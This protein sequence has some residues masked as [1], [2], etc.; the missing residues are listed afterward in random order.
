MKS[1]KQ[2]NEMLT[3]YVLGELSPVDKD[4]VRYHLENCDQ[5]RDQ[6]NRLERLINYADKMGEVG[7]DEQTCEQARETLLAVVEN[8][9]G[10]QSGGAVINQLPERRNIMKNSIFKLSA[11][12]LILIA[13]VTAVCIFTINNGQENKGRRIAGGASEEQHR[14]KVEAEQVRIDQM[15]A[16]HDVD[17]L[18]EMVEIG[19]FE[20]KLRAAALLGEIGDVR[21]LPALRN[22][23][24]VD[25]P[26]GYT[27]EPVVEAIENIVNST[28]ESV[29]DGTQDSGVTSSTEEGTAPEPNAVVAVDKQLLGLIPAETAFCAIVNNFDNAFG[30]IDQYAVGISPVPGA[31]TVGARALIVGKLGNPALTGVNTAGSF[32]VFGKAFP[33]EP[34]SNPI[35]NLLIGFLVP[36]PDYE[37]FVEGN[38]NFGAAD[39]N[40]ISI[41]KTGGTVN[42]DKKQLGARLGGYVLV[43]PGNSYDKLVSVVKSV[44]GGEPGI[45]T[46]LDA[47]MA[48][49][50][51]KDSLWGYS[52]VPRI[53]QVFGP[54]IYSQIEKTK[55][56][57]EKLNQEDSKANVPPS[58]VMNMYFGMLEIITKELDSV[59]VGLNYTPAVGTFKISVSPVA[60][61]YLAKMF[62]TDTSDTEN[63]YLGYLEDGAV[64]NV[65]FKINKNLLQEYFLSSFDLM[66]FLDEEG[67]PEESLLKAEE[68]ISKAI[69]LMGEGV[70]CV[71]AGS[72][73]NTPFSARYLFEVSDKDS[74]YKLEEEFVELWNNGG[75]A[76]AYKKIG[77]DS[78]YSLQYGI[79]DYNGVIIDGAKFG[80]KPFGDPNSEYSQM[81]E[82]MYGGGID[83]KWTILDGLYVGTMGFDAANAS[84]SELHGLIDQVQ[85]GIKP[86]VS[87]ETQAALDVL[88]NAAAADLVGTI[89][90]V[91]Y[92][93]MTAGM[94]QGAD[95][96]TAEMMD[97]DTETSGNIAFAVSI[98]NDKGIVE[99]AVPKDH[100][101]EIKAANEQMQQNMEAFMAKQQ[102]AKNIAS[103]AGLDQEN[104]ANYEALQKL[105]IQADLEVLKVP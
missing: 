10:P 3:G 39:V 23:A 66:S 87:S 58:S 25:M 20:S 11:A 88:D 99:V 70:L 77:M 30:M 53:S 84:T 95:P 33:G 48:E 29:P 14:I 94:M 101:L 31:V 91:R 5:C 52:N 7:V 4:E 40:G 86:K 35:E 69:N 63:K 34:N 28:A 17:G 21:A 78:N 27:E 85:T 82:S 22:L 65:G 64:F 62:S 26:E 60:D 18:I 67:I 102:T 80:M 45:R 15:A 36:V 12:A 100:I 51:M 75:F 38:P 37:K 98:K 79:E 1:H 83:Y 90:I 56:M 43:G 81:V 50:A 13:A 42:P 72:E 71:G 93:R 96:M 73:G 59:S 55:V 49:S 41:I 104:I 32:A 16:D 24:S 76:V 105:D 57:L 97:V 19:E 2:I 6:V 61:T 89:N 46:V 54:M 9:S 47:D 74:F 44:S 8:E 103:A 92:M 68:L